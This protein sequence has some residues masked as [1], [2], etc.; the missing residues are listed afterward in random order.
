M[1]RYFDMARKSSVMMAQTVCRPR[2]IGP[3]SQQPLRKNPVTGAVEQGASAVP[4]TLTEAS[5]MADMADSFP[6]KP[7]FALWRGLAT[8]GNRPMTGS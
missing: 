3:V 4:R 6:L 5:L 8:G 7:Q 2:S 1:P